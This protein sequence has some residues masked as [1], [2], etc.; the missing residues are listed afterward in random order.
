[1]TRCLR[2][3]HRAIRRLAGQK[4]FPHCALNGGCHCGLTSVSACLTGNVRMTNRP[5][6][7]GIGWRCLNN[8]SNMGESLTTTVATA[9]DSCRGGQYLRY[10]NAALLCRVGMSSFV[11]FASQ[12]RTVGSLASMRGNVLFSTVVECRVNRR[13]SLGKSG[14]VALTFGFLGTSF[15]IGTREHLGAVRR[16]IGTKGH[17]NRIETRQTR[18]LGQAGQAGQAGIRFIRRARGRRGAR[19]TRST[20]GTPSSSSRRPTSGKASRAG[21]A[22]IRFIRRGMVLYGR[23]GYGR[24]SSSS[25]GFS[26]LASFSSSSSSSSSSTRRRTTGFR[27]GRISSVTRRMERFCGDR[28]GG[29]RKDELVRYG[30]LAPRQQ[31]GVVARMGTCNVSTAGRTVAGTMGDRFLGCSTGVTPMGVR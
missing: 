3:R 4:R 29:A 28:V 30:I 11:V 5:T 9:A 1:M 7:P 22:G 24:V 8:M 13:M 27:G 18:R 21:Q 6:G 25:S 23:V 2:Y 26:S 17:D 15:S 10:G 31:T 16:E 12:C 20:R 14:R 19:S